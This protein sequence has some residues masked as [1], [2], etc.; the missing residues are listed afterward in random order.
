MSVTGNL[1]LRRGVERGICLICIGIP[2]VLSLM[3]YK[4]LQPSVLHTLMWDTNR[5]EVFQILEI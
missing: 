4:E 1:E 2:F 5:P 3:G